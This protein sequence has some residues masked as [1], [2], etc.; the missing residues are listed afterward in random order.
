M[1][2]NKELT[3][4]SGNDAYSRLGCPLT[5][6]LCFCYCGSALGAV[7]SV[8]G[9][10]VKTSGGNSLCSLTLT[11]FNHVG[12]KLLWF[13]LSFSYYRQ[14]FASEP[15]GTRLLPTY[16]KNFPMIRLL[17]LS[18]GNHLL[19]PSTSGCYY[20]CA[21]DSWGRILCLEGPH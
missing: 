10:A 1:F 2:L 14:W 3:M 11:P 6:N 17:S 4:K 12:Y 18:L 21:P 15:P 7:T 9:Y 8:T 16:P 20:Y 13:S 5:P 19:G